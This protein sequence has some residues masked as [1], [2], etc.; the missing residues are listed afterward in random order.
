M[1]FN[2]IKDYLNKGDTEVFTKSIMPFLKVDKHLEAGEIEAES[3]AQLLHSCVSNWQE[4]HTTTQEMVLDSLE[5][6]IDK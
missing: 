4:N 6:A 5:D 3:L 1:Q 2:H